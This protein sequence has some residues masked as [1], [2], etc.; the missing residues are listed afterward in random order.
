MSEAPAEEEEKG[1]DV[2]EHPILGK[3][4]NLAWPN[5][6]DI[7]AMG[8]FY[9]SPTRVEDLSAILQTVTIT[10]STDPMV[11]G[12]TLLPTPTTK[13]DNL[14]PYPTSSDQKSQWQAPSEWEIARD[15][16]ESPGSDL[17]STQ[18]KTPMASPKLPAKRILSNDSTTLTAEAASRFQEFVRQIEERGLNV[19][20]DRLREDWSDAFIDASDKEELTLE[21][22]LWALTA[23]QLDCI[24]DQFSRVGMTRCLIPGT[25]L[26]PV[27]QAGKRRKI[28]ELDGAIGTYNHS[29]TTSLASI[30]LHLTFADVYIGEIYQLS[31]MYPDSKIDHLLSHSTKSKVTIPSQARQKSL[32][33]AA[34]TTSPF[35]PLPYASSSMHHIRSSRLATLIPS[36]QIPQLLAECHRVLKPGGVLELRV[37]DAAPQRQ[38]L[39]PNLAAWLEER[40]L[41]GLEAKFRCSR[42][43]ALVPQW[44]KQAGFVPM[45]STVHEFERPDSLKRSGVVRC[46]RLP[47]AMGRA[48][49]VERTGVLVELGLLLSRTL[50]KDTWGSY[51]ADVEGES[52]WWWDSDM[53]LSECADWGTVFEV[54]T[55]VVV[56]EG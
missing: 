52:R 47:A 44:A 43:L 26:P 34:P 7:Q 32:K 38:C 16:K 55:L 20:L 56:K 19:L 25:P 33:T 6:M 2:V 39:G 48:P 1:G 13:K 37:M 45:A 8:D 28:L 54:A 5:Q 15:D 51:V 14:S 24:A 3:D 35:L 50:W 21:K 18:D 53:I 4:G 17:D 30:R 11:E 10:V 29:L 49:L 31:A 36:S 22:H 42:P 41:V 40:L 27:L 46:L 9:L 12:E 23:L